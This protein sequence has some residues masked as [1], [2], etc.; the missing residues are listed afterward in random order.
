MHQTQSVDNRIAAMQVT[1]DFRQEYIRVVIFEFKDILQ[2][3]K[4]VLRLKILHLLS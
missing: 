2:E 3:W 4:K 1:T